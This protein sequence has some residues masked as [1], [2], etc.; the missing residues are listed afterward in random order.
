MADTMDEQ[1]VSPSSS[2]GTSGPFVVGIAGGTGSGKTTLAQGIVARL[3]SDALVVTHDSYYRAHDDLPYE[4]RCL[5][6]YDHPDAYETELMVAQLRELIA[7]RPVACPVYDF[8]AHNRA[9]ETHLLRPAR[10]IVVEGILVLADPA[11]RELMDLK[12]FVDCPADVRI[13]RR[14]ARDVAE[15]GRSVD[16]V[17]SQYLST[18]RPM[19]EAYVEP[20][21]QYA[22]LIVPALEPCDA[23]LDLIATAL[24]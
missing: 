1:T 7:G 14:L 17:V 8:A 22:D 15:R 20:S 5:L 18:V 3:G 19:H 10:V 13:L 21:K 4:E 9:S 16:S 11:L 2:F 6:N 12:V 23:A 24:T